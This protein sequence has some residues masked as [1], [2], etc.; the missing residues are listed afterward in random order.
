MRCVT[1]DTNVENR[2]TG[3]YKKFNFN[4]MEKF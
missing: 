4:G 1:M 3:Q 2:A